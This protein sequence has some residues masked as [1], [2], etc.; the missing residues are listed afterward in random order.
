MTTDV[1]ALTTAEPR[2][3]ALRDALFCTGSRTV[4]VSSGGMLLRLLGRAGNTAMAVAAPLPVRV[5]GQVTRLLGDVPGL[6][7]GPL[8]WTEARTHIRSRG[9]DAMLGTF[10]SRLAGAGGVVWPPRLRRADPGSDVDPGFPPLTI[11]AQPALDLVGPTSAVVHQDRRVVGVSFWL[12]DA[13]AATLASSPVRRLDIVTGP[14]TKLTSQL[15]ELLNPRTLRWVVH[16]GPE[17]YDGRT[18]ESLAWEGPHTGGTGMPR[19]VRAPRPRPVVAEPWRRTRE[20]QL[21]R[22]ALGRTGD[23]RLTLHVTC[24][25]QPSAGLV[26]GRVAEAVWRAV[27]DELPSG[28]GTQEPLGAPWSTEHLTALARARMPGPTYLLVAG[29]GT[30]PAAG[31]LRVTRT[32]DGVVEGLSV[33][34]GYPDGDEVPDARTLRS[35]ARVL[36]EE[37]GLRSLFASVRSASAD[38]LD[39][40]GFPGAPGPLALA[41]HTGGTEGSRPGLSGER[42]GAAHRYHAFSGDPG[43][44]RDLRSLSEEYGVP[45]G[46]WTD[47]P[48]GAAPGAKE[49]YTATGY[50]V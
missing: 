15:T 8:W 50:A 1:V 48:A 17:L 44:W 18:G 46:T 11:A 36:A 32:G 49:A 10:A 13:L 33:S 45:V 23:R 22:A 41:L 19:P 43:Q 42:I 40:P 27:T 4:E 34:F 35:L 26:V 9:G 39:A 12:Q 16:D 28:W 6:P 25:H 24:G 47:P 30:R 21:T 14:D 20:S 5:P 38:L 31:S 37:H 3:E 29:S 2:R 7:D